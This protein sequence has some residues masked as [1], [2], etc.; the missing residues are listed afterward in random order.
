MQRNLPNEKSESFGRFHSRQ[1]VRNYAPD[2]SD[3][4][5]TMVTLLYTS[6]QA[7]QK[8]RKNA[9][10]ATCCHTLEKRVE[11]G[12]LGHPEHQMVKLSTLIRH[13]HIV[14][15]QDLENYL[16]TTLP[17][18]HA[19]Q[20]LLP[21]INMRHPDCEPV[22]EEA[23]THSQLGSTCDHEAEIDSLKLT[24]A[25]LME[26]N[27]YLRSQLDA[28][29][30]QPTVDDDLMKQLQQSLSVIKLRQQSELSFNQMVDQRI[31]SLTEVCYRILFSQRL[32]T[33]HVLESTAKT[34][35]LT[36]AVDEL[37]SEVSD[38]FHHKIPELAL[39]KRPGLDAV[40]AQESESLPKKLSK[41][42]SISYR[43]SQLPG[44]CK[45]PPA[46]PK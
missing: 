20:V 46:L 39:S 3:T 28:Q 34:R 43:I 19:G 21:Q 16:K 7:Y 4:F 23:T 30:K 12:S 38:L 22:R 40:D 25:E 5:K 13:H 42:D 27:T 6:V 8:Y 18:N 32:N 31:S 17:R 24:V 41:A 33:D 14:S 9:R 10:W 36:V 44:L 26:E 11:R 1:H 35:N 15:R 37:R 45:M 2:N 29:S